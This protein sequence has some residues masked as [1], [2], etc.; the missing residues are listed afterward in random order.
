MAYLKPQSPL[1]YKDGDYFYPLTT[2]DQVVMKDGSRLNSVFKHSVRTNAILL[3]SAW[4]NIAPYIQT[5]TLDENVDIELNIDVNI[6]YTGELENDKM[7]NEA[8]ACLTYIKKEGNNIV[9][10][11]LKKKPEIDIPIEIEGVCVNSIATIEEGIK[12]PVLTNEGTASDLFF[13]KELIDQ[14]GNIITGTYE[15]ELN[16]EIVGGT[17]EPE[18]P[19][20]NTIWI[21]TDVPIVWW[22]FYGGDPD[23]SWGTNE[24]IVYITVNTRGGAIRLNIL[25]NNEITIFPVRAKQKINGTY[26]DVEAKIYQNGQW[27]DWTVYLFSNGTLNETVTGGITGTLG[28][29][30]ISF[31]STTIAAANNKTY[32]TNKPIDLT[33]ANT[34]RMIF[35]PTATASN[36]NANAYFRVVVLSAPQTGVNVNTFHAAYVAHADINGN[37]WTS[38]AN[39]EWSVD[40]SSLEGE[41]YLGYA[42]GVYSAST[43][44]KTLSGEISQWWLE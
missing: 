39:N 43:S 7:L 3:A 27:V 15:G 19:K 4:T 33:N 17:T 21:N 25:K 14:N 18:N 9:F 2:V 31:P 29:G 23:E 36:V 1:Q 12:L 28:D 10:Y 35:K 40:V 22:V 24:G 5:I 41:Y 30:V 26:V 37:Q 42:F 44:S 11:C 6:A 13:G 8:A 16:F 20:E 34:V 38:G 32:S